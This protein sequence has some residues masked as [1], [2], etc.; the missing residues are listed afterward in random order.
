MAG[1]VAAARAGRGGPRRLVPG[2]PPASAG[3][4]QGDMSSPTPA[5]RVPRTER[6]ASVSRVK[7]HLGRVTLPEGVQRALRV[8]QG[9]ATH[10]VCTFV[11]RSG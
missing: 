7:Q 10:V 2:L 1:D 5:V 6:A 8:Q 3:T 11:N 4:P 9:R